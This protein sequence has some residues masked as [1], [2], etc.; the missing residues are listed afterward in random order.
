[1]T[2][3]YDIQLNQAKQRMVENLL[4]IDKICKKNHIQYWL[5]FGSMLGAVRHQ[6][7]IPWDDDLDISMLRA[8]YEKFIQI[9]PKEL[10]EYLFLQTKQ[11]DPHYTKLVTKIRDTRTKF[12]EQEENSNEKYQQGLFI[13][14]FPYDFYSP[15]ALKT[16]KLMHFFSN[17]RNHRHHYRKGSLKRLLFN[18]I[19]I[20]CLLCISSLK[21]VFKFVHNTKNTEGALALEWPQPVYGN[22]HELTD[23]FPLHDHV[24]ENNL[25][26]IPNQA[27]KLL[28]VFYGDWK[29]FPPLEDRI[30]HAKE[31][32]MN[33]VENKES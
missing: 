13:D 16:F 22:G 30:P 5:D 31:I 17:L 8:D 27:E 6:G 11:T 4:I 20:P 14:I 33:Y 1:M 23:F 2:T 28:T 12:V 9:A 29:S 7:F 32:I 3:A 10:P 18:L 15:V 25:F 21:I 26:P 24:F 19:S